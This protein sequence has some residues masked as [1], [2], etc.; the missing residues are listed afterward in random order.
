VGS[1]AGTGSFW[2][3]DGGASGG[4]VAEVGGIGSVEAQGG[5]AVWGGGG[6]AADVRGRASSQQQGSE[7]VSRVIGVV[8]VLRLDRRLSRLPST[9]CLIVPASS[10]ATEVISA[11][12]LDL[13]GPVPGQIVVLP[14]RWQEGNGGFGFGLL[15]RVSRGIGR[16]EGGHIN[17]YLAVV[18]RDRC[19]GVPRH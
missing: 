9:P 11:R 6:V 18:G 17:C 19:A 5:R 8:K 14:V 10:L 16:R 13:V 4:G 7:P 12:R 1:S 15:R 3:V 2:G